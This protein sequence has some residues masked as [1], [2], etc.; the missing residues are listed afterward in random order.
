M[1]A[2]QKFVVTPN[3]PEPLK[4]LLEIAGNIWWSWNVEAISLLRRIDPDLWDKHAGNPI[5]VLGSLSAQR[6]SDLAKD[7]AFL[8]HM[9]RVRNDL[10]R[11]L[12][13]SSWYEKEHGPDHQEVLGYFSLEFGLHESLPLYSGGLGILAGDHLKS[14]SD[15]GLPLV[16][17]GLAYQYGYF[18][19]YLNHDG[20]QMEDYQIN[21]FYNMSMDLVRDQEN[22]PLTIEITYP[23]RTVTAQIWRVP[24]GRNPL[25]LL[26]TNL[27]KNLPEDRDLT[28]RLYGGDNDMRIRQ[29]IL[30]G[31]GGLRALVALGMEPT[32]CHLNEGHSAFLALERIAMLMEK[33]ELAFDTAFEIVR[34]SNVFTTHTPVPA[35]NDHF[36]ADLVRTYLPRMAERLG[37]GVDGL[38]ALGRQ[39]PTNK[40]ETFCMT[41][42]ALRLSRFANGVSELHGHVSRKMWQQ[43]WKGVPE[44]EIPIS[45]VTNGV[46]TRSWLCSE[47]ARL[48]DR[49]LGPRWF[50]EPTNKTMWDRVDQIPDAEL[51][52]SH[53]RMRERLVGFVRRRL[54][55]QLLARG[56][57]R[58][59]VREASEVLDPEALTIGFARR[60][61]TYKR[62]A[63]LLRDPARLSRIL[64]DPDRPVQ[65]IFAGKA[66]PK[67]HPGKEIIRQLVHLGQQPEFRKRITFVEDYN[68]EVARYMVQGVD[69]WL[70]TPRR[71]LEASGT[72]GM[73]VPANGGINLSILDG[74]WCEGYA[75]NNGWAIGAGEDYED[76]EYQDEV[77]STALY[78]LLENEIVPTYYD[79]GSDD[80]PR[81]WTRIMKNSMRTVNAEFNTNRMVEEYTNRFY[82]T[83][84][85]NAARL[86]ADDY[87]RAKDLADWRRRTRDE[88]SQVKIRCVDDPVN[89]AQPMGET[90]KVTAHLHL[91]KIPSEEVLVE[92][93]HGLLNAEGQIQDG[94]TATLFPGETGT[95]GLTLFCGDIPCRRA[96][97][98]GYTV[99]VVPRKEGYPLDRF[100][101]GLITWWGVPDAGS[102]SKTSSHDHEPARTT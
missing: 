15:L 52:R 69:V 60:F 8:A 34:A 9:E 10:D 68:I 36:H 47:I 3:L 102:C 45:Y 58:V 76:Q 65:L 83:C 59:W 39:D 97:L 90:L 5:A 92:A 89:T 31:I 7:A 41:V 43:V 24:V 91:G 71:P 23:G 61:A 48:F 70:N 50:E 54:G 11:Y 56:A 19:Q 4:P 38:L 40:H 98:R 82:V 57:N 79:R 67:D 62:A 32:V 25:F 49:Y 27:P 73:K 21:D 20:W 17:V 13:I 1:P 37:L 16:G 72:S 94:E 95:D 18:R 30:L 46:H 2:I 55:H 93:Y 33:K 63:L 22:A 14:A 28:S 77:E 78:D 88:W 12:N 51:W 84:I 64:N 42:L 96:G 53:E 6:V 66:H 99:R 81:E 101:T 35:G 87:S 85:Q 75:K 74:W 86:S 100:E 26:D 80:V 44:E 29:E